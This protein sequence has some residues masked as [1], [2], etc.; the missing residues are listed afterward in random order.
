M[1][2]IEINKVAEILKKNKADP[3]LLRSVVEEMNLLA[4]AAQEAD[5]DKPKAVKKQN[6]I[7]ISDPEGRLLMADFAAWE[8]QIPDSES[9][10]TTLDRIYRATYEFNASKKGR[11]YPAKTV[12]EALE[13]VPAKFFKDH[14]L[15]VRTKTPVLV[16][17]TNNLI[18]RK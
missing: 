8:L 17:R 11:L 9:P 13:N 16:C 18:P 4:Q 15:W 10:C 3:K 12:G 2:K 14:E 6:V 5:E 1:S 7:L